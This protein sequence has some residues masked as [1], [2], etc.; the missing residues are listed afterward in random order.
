MIGS[1]FVNSALICS[2][3][4]SSEAR[5]LLVEFVGEADG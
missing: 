2:S 5:G 4:S 3:S 1:S